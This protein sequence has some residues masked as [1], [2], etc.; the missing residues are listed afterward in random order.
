MKNE[1]LKPL[2]GAGPFQAASLT[3]VSIRGVY[4]LA[5]S[6]GGRGGMAN[7]GALGNKPRRLRSS[8]KYGSFCNTRADGQK[9]N[10][11]PEG[12]RKPSDLADNALGT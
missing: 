5:I 12:E 1:A 8:I 9:N 11:A 6:R 7:Q 3:A 2:A 10:A 4:P